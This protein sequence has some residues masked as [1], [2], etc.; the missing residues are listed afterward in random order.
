MFPTKALKIFQ[1]YSHHLT[2]LAG[3]I[4]LAIAVWMGISFIT[5]INTPL[6]DSGA[7]SIDFVYTQ[8]SSVRALVMRLYRKNILVHP[9]FF[10]TLA[11]MNGSIYHLQ[12]GE[13]RIEPNMRPGELLARMVKGEGIMHAFT[14]VEGWTFQQVIKTLNNNSYVEHTLAGLPNDAL[15]RA[16]GHEGEMPEGR[17]AADTYLF[18]AGIKDA[19]LLKLA[20]KF[21]AE[22]LA[23]E[24]QGRALNLPYRCSYD[25]L[26]AASIIEK[27]TAIP[28]ER[29]KIAGVI[30]RRLE[31]NMPLEMDPTVIYA[32]THDFSAPYQLTK[33][34]LAED[35]LY[36]TYLHKGL[37]PTPISMPSKS[38]IN[39]AL[40][41]ENSDVLYYV[42]KGDGSK[43]HVFSAH[44]KE[45]QV[46]VKQ[47]RMKQ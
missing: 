11:K 38:S 7:Q 20:Y 22:R 10:L 26:I 33:T 35:S 25:A 45:H 47:L 30:V 5:F 21:L 36:N 16:I 1:K 12:A 4:A 32:K 2:V 15:M 37:P 9:L 40:H 19:T 34:D 41:P 3:A 43:E 13:Y 42:A 39:A 17:F 24:W 23:K 44:Y 27:E 6:L 18:H 46:A 28:E 8:G 29:V 31:K 14:I